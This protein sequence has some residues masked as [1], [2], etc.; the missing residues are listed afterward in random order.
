MRFRFCPLGPVEER[1]DG[2]LCFHRSKCRF[3]VKMIVFRGDVKVFPGSGTS[4][5]ALKQAIDWNVAPRPCELPSPLA[6]G[7]RRGPGTWRRLL[8]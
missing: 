4:R 1:K 5:L 6:D 7:S 3:L 8:L 2:F